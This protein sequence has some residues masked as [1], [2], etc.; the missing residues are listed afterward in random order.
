MYDLGFSVGPNGA[1]FFVDVL[2]V[3]TLMKMANFVRAGSAGPVESSRSIK[4]DGS[5]GPQTKR[6]IKAF[7]A[8]R[9]ASRLL[10]VDD[11]MFEPSRGDGFTRSG[12]LF[13][14]IHL[15]RMAKDP[16]FNNNYNALPFAPTTHPAL[17][18]ALVNG[19][20]RPAGV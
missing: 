8:D 18:Q 1:N 20:I 5:F 6:M 10:L 13:K 9:K 16:P 3:Q 19:A 2:L 7:E 14:I 11:G 4:V 12:M 17:R 15:N